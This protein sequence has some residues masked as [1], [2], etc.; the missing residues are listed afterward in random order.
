MTES[1]YNNMIIAYDINNTFSDCDYNIHTIRACFDPV[2]GKE[3]KQVEWDLIH[4]VENLCAEIAYDNS[5][6]DY[7]DA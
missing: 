3:L 4:Y 6:R 1:K 2:N 7:Y 5:W